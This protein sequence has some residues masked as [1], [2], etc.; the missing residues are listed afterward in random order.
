MNTAGH[1]AVIVA[2]GKGTRMRS[3]KRK[4]YLELDGVPVLV[5]T[6]RVFDSHFATSAMV[7]VVPGAELTFCRQMVSEYGIETPIRY[8]AGGVERQDSVENGLRLAS[9]LSQDPRRTLVMVHD[10]VR[11]FVSHGIVDGC[12]AMAQEMGAAIPALK[13][14]DT[15][16]TVDESGRIVNTLNRSMLY[17]AQTPQTFRLDLGLSAFAHA[18]QSGFRG[19]D[20]ASILEHMGIPVG[21]VPGAEANI[22]LTTPQDLAMAKWFLSG[23]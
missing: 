1:I 18:R 10:G 13:I 11:P 12:L 17:R 22:K 8:A 14:S 6:L 21:I 9:E 7:L 3:S 23:R 20:E 19:T 4:Q 5:H 16:K 2:A 15:I